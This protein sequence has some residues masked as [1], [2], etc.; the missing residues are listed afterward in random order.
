MGLEGFVISRTSLGLRFRISNSSGFNLL[1][2]NAA[3]HPSGTASNTRLAGSGCDP[4]PFLPVVGG[5]PNQM[6]AGF[7]H[8]SLCI[9]T[10]A[11]SRRPQRS[12][13]CRGSMGSIR[14]NTHYMVL[15]GN[16][17]GARVSE[18]TND[19]KVDRLTRQ[20]LAA[21]EGAKALEE[22]AKRAADV[23][24]NMARLRELR[25]A[26]EAQEVRT[27]ISA[28]NQSKPKPKNRFR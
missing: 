2:G 24:A 18:L 14:R 26:K 20:R 25:L 22:I 7:W 27:E 11:A 4:K 1:D 9:E 23:R 5:H 10:Q 17:I 16:R 21:E 12:S 15:W 3:A 28:A 13:A 19:L 6:N 8:V